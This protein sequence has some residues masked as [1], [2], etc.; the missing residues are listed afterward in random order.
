MKTH[1]FTFNRN[2]VLGLGYS[3]GGRQV[4]P[5]DFETDMCLP[6]FSRLPKKFQAIYYETLNAFPLAHSLC[7]ILGL[8]L[9]LQNSS[10]WPYAYQTTF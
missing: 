5:S 6:Q 10:L 2:I 7:P 9:L 1:T 8:S 3:P 4:P